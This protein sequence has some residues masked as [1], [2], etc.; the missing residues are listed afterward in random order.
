MAE[1]CQKG[2][3]KGLPLISQIQDRL[4]KQHQKVDSKLFEGGEKEGFEDL[5][6][7]KGKFFEGEEAYQRYDDILEEK[8]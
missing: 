4:R 7:L 6:A 8:R 2:Y 5:K 1:H 3:S